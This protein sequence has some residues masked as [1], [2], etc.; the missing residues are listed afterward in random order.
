MK[1]MMMIKGG[2]GCEGGAAPSPELD[3]AIGK[4]IGE[5]TQS[6]VLVDVGGLLPSAAGAL[7]R[8][9]KSKITVTDGPF[10]EARELIGGYAIVK[11]GSRAEAMRLAED[12]MKLHV[13]I[14]G[15]EYEGVCEVRQM[16]E[17]PEAASAS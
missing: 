15:P 10:T 13:D 6:G 9:S 16:F 7:V 4:L 1:F 3:A 12:F 17:A 8:A 5:M 2:P 14:L 11:V